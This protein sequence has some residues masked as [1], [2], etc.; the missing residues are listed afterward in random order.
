[1]EVVEYLDF[2]VSGAEPRGV[3]G[4]VL[5]TDNSLERLVGLFDFPRFAHFQTQKIAIEAQHALHIRSRERNVMNT[6][7]HDVSSGGDGVDLG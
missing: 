6:V 5:Q 2:H 7:D 3:K 1:M 4:G